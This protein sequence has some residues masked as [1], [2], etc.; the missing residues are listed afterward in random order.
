MLDE[1][2]SAEAEEIGDALRKLLAKESSPER[3]RKA[4]ASADGRDAEL[5]RQL[6][7]FGINDLPADPGVLSRVCLELGRALAP[8]AIAE[9]LPAKIILGEEGVAYGLEGDVPAALARVALPDPDGGVS[10]SSLQ[11]PRRRS[12]AGDFLVRPE[13]GAD[14]RRVGD[15][16]VAVRMRRLMRLLDAARLV[17]AGQGLLEIGVKYSKERV[18]S[19]RPIAA[20][21]AVAHRLSNAATALDAA[22]LLLRKAAFTATVDA[23][24][25][26]APSQP[27]AV[28]ARAKA[29]E[30]ARLVATN[31][32]QVMGGY[33]FT[34]DYDCQLYSRRIRS[35]SMRLA[36]PGPELAQLA[37]L[38]LAPA[39]R[40]S[41]R[42]LWHHEQGVPLPR[43]AA[44]ADAR[45]PA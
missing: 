31:V 28:M 25:D 12:A 13:R 41:V 43:W 10:I 1:R 37:R 27:F 33:G 6:A 32:H 9:S 17:G 14:A 24:G 7:E 15:S 29:V 20:F 34:I 5:E 23:G 38:L 35:W 42:L 18:Q 44:G 19:G 2:W 39:L 8:V 22:V 3:V 40:D 45:A 30:A 36:R 26:L 16:E 11:G 21:Q 4:E